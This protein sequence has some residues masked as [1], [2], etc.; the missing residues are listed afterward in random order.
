MVNWPF[1]IKEKTRMLRQMRRAKRLHRIQEAFSSG[2]P[3][4]LCEQTDSF[5]SDGPP[6]FSCLGSGHDSKWMRM[7]RIYDAD[8]LS[9]VY[10]IP[11]GRLKRLSVS[12]E[13]ITERGLAQALQLNGST[14][15]E[16]R[17]RGH[18]GGS[19]VQAAL[20]ACI[21][22]RVLDLWG[23]QAHPPSSAHSLEEL[24]LGDGVPPPAVEIM[25]RFQNLR[26]LR[27]FSLWPLDLLPKVCR[28]C[29]MLREI[30]MSHP[31]VTNELLACLMLHARHLAC[32]S[33]CRNDM[34]GG[35]FQLQQGGIGP[36]VMFPFAEGARALISENLVPAAVEAFKKHFPKADIYVDWHKMEQMQDEMMEILG[37]GGNDGDDE[38]D[39]NHGGDDEDYSGRNE[40]S[41]DVDNN[42][43]E[44]TYEEGNAEYLS[45][46]HE[47]AVEHMSPAAEITPEEA[48]QVVAEQ[49][50]GLIERLIGT[51]VIPDT[52]DSGDDAPE[53]IYILKLNRIP[54]FIRRDLS[55]SNSLARCRA[56]LHEA[57]YP[58]K[59]MEGAFVFVHPH[60]Y[61]QVMASS[62]QLRP[63]NVIVSASMEHLVA[64][65]L[66]N[67]RIWAKSRDVLVTSFATPSNFQHGNSEI[68]DRG[69]HERTGRFLVKNTFLSTVPDQLE[70]AATCSDSDT[71]LHWSNPRRCVWS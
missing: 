39:G 20:D 45:G 67:T 14:L 2:R 41:E 43:Q 15:S 62:R 69:S 11:A 31:M 68:G 29:V 42:I 48:A 33:G 34:G 44:A 47:Q 25:H 57:G 63:D 28:N 22:L 5:D 18:L 61:R 46:V 58:W 70:E 1:A 40:S 10:R 6:R 71:Q 38:D 64:E 56:A 60:Q 13:H 19:D 51:G 26:V 8:L 32:F 49:E 52:E 37:H 27:I 4:P 65:V 54:S 66:V 30:H 17:L 36:F 23:V 7:T 53:D 24:N 3:L 16:L 12:S 55:I 21:G 50:S 59:T 9:A 35:L